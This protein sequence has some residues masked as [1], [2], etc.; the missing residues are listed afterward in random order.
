MGLYIGNTRYC[1]ITNKENSLPYDSEINYLQGD[2]NAYIMTSLKS[3]ND[4][5]EFET[6]VSCTNSGSVILFGA[7][8]GFN[9]T[10]N[11]NIYRC[12]GQVISN[13]TSSI[14]RFDTIKL[15]V[16]PAQNSIV[17]TINGTDYTGTYSSWIYDNYFGIFGSGSG[18]NISNA[19]IKY[20]KIKKN[21]ILVKYYIPVRLRQTG[22][23]Y[24]T[25]GG[26]LYGNFGSGNFVLGSDIT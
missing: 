6:E 8:N 19:K 2:E 10:V 25:E 17:L 13:V 9:V 5:W 21:N 1:L 3:S 12:T 4:I 14:D 7:I 18:S 22:Y 20:L 15:V 16:N 26:I 11:N 24:E 23:M